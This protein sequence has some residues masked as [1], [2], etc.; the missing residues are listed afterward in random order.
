MDFG[1]FKKI[2]DECVKHGTY[3]IR[4]SFRG[5][6]F[7]HKDVIEMI[8]YAKNKGIKEV[9]SLTNNLTMT[10]SLFKEVLDAGLDWLT[11]SFDGLAEKY[12]WIRQP[13]KFDESLEKIKDYK[14]IK[15]NHNTTKPVIKVQ[16]V[17]PAVKSNVRE[18]FELF[19]PYVDDIAFNPLIDYLRKDREIIYDNDFVCPVLY[20]RLVIGSD[21][22][23][24]LCICDELCLHPIG[25]ANKEYLFDIW[26]GKK[27]INARETHKKH[28]GVE[29]L[30]PCKDCY[31]PRRTQRVIKHLGDK[32]IYI[33]KFI[34]RPDVVGK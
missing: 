2:V 19:D 18:Y 22:I 30:E 15:D 14:R 3:S 33:D 8:R 29:L 21:G 26:H 31:L 28:K 32:E 25:D 34:N 4:L 17:W 12:E 24:L 1:L 13:A 27:M 16:S 9:S 23:A 6:P 10:P 11:I 20:Q 7:I 5:E